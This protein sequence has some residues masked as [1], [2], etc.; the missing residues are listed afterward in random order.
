MRF[1]LVWRQLGLWLLIRAVHA[2]VASVAPGDPRLSL[3]SAISQPQPAVVLVCLALGVVEIWRRRERILLGNLG[4]GW[5]QL[6]A[7]LLAPPIVAEAA[8]GLSRGW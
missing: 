6:A 3:S 2:L 1:A 5:E 4:I 7:L 8:V